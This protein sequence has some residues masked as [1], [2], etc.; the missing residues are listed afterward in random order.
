MA[1]SKDSRDFWPLMIIFKTSSNFLQIFA[2]N[3]NNFHTHLKLVSVMIIRG[4]HII[5]TITRKSEYT[6]VKIY[7][8]PLKFNMNVVLLCYVEFISN[9]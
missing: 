1:E 2:K 3:K 4:F 7:F 6:V 8:Q 9:L 5:L